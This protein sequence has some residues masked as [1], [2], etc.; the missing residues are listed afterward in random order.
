MPRMPRM[1]TLP[2]GVINEAGMED[3]EIPPNS[4][5]PTMRPL[6]H[7]HASSRLKPRPLFAKRHMPSLSRSELNANAEHSTHAQPP[8]PWSAPTPVAHTTTRKIIAA[9][10]SSTAQ[11]PLVVAVA[12]APYYDDTDILQLI[13]NSK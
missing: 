4:M 8:R 9:A 6:A 11:T 12:P 2:T 1:A 10:S 3:E 13:A 7:S 5:S